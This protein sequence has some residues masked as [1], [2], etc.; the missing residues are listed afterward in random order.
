MQR[1]LMLL[2]K[3][4]VQPRPKPQ[5]QPNRLP[6]RL[7]PCVVM[8]VPARARQ[9]PAPAAGRGGKFGDRKDSRS[10]PGA[11]NPAAHARAPRQQVQTLPRAEREERAPRGERP[12]FEDRGPRLGDAAFRAQREAFEA[13]NQAL[14]KLAMQAHGEVLTNLLTAWEKRD[15]AQLPSAQD[16]GKLVTPAVRNSW[17]QAVSKP[18]GKDAAESLLRL[19][20]AAELPTPAEHIS[21]RRMLQLQLLTK[22][23]AP[24]PA[25]TWG[26]DAAKVLAGEFDAGNARRVQNALKVLLKR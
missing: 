1:H 25:E 7:L 14:K 18:A 4:Q 17:V 6:S 9:K 13:A 16:L 15:P 3:K 23:N 2:K 22:R 10:G 26:D 5:H 8:T 21:A 19:E 24:A 12:A 11:A 20:I